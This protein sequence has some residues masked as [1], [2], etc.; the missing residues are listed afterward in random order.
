MFVHSIGYTQLLPNKDT[1]YVID[2]SFDEEVFYDALDSTNV[3]LRTN[4]VTLVKEA[5]IRYG[6]ITMTA[7][8]IIIDLDKN[9]VTA[10]YLTDSVGNQTGRPQFDDGI[11]KMTASTIRYNFN[12]EKGISKMS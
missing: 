4:R 5:I 9:E 2:D 1:V 6:D 12:T 11:E 8:Y 10:T 3:D 7:D